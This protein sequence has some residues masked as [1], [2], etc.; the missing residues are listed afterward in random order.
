MPC[1]ACID[2]RPRVVAIRTA[3]EAVHALLRCA[4]GPEGGTSEASTAE[5]CGVANIRELDRLV[6]A[7]FACHRRSIVRDHVVDDETCEAQV[8][9]RYERRVATLQGGCGACYAEILAL[10]VPGLV[11]DAVRDLFCSAP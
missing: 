11:G 3:V 10:A 5:R 9:A 4:P 1:R 2:A 8:T 6:R 7:L